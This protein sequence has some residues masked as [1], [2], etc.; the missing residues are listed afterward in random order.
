[1]TVPTEQKEAAALLQRLSG[2]APIE[3]P[4]SAVFV[5]RLT[6][7]KLK[8]AVRM[9]FADFTAA[10]DRQRFVQREL[11][12]NK[13]LAPAVYRDFAAIVRTRHDTLAIT[14]EPDGREVLD[15]VLRMAPVPADWF[16]DRPAALAQLT[17]PRLDALADLIAAYHAGLSPVEDWD[18]AA[19]LLAVVEENA[20]SAREAGLPEPAVSVWHQAAHAALEARRPWF[21]ARARAGLVRRAHGDLHLGN[22]LLWHGTPMPFDAL[23][24][25]EAMATIDLGYDL[26]FLLMDLDLKLGREASNRVLNRY[27]ARTLDFGLVAGLPLFLSL[28][29]MVR[30]HVRR[31]GDHP[32]S[33]D[34]LDAALRYLTP[35]SRPAPVVAIGGLPGTGKSTL[36][37][38]LAAT[39]GP[40]PG[41]VVLRSDEIRKRQHGVAPEQRLPPEAY[42]EAANRQVMDAV[43]AGLRGIAP[44]GHAAIAD[45]TFLDP[46][47]RAAAEQAARDAGVPFVGLWLHARLS[48]LE[49]RIAARRHDASDADVEVLHRAAE[50]DAGPINWTRLDATDADRALRAAERA[51]RKVCG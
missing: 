35:P 20:V 29:A 46:A 41:A 11:E 37:R 31:R 16:C 34:Y 44:A 14:P 12:L 47:H 25:D 5:G 21:T 15:W 51:I 7:W 2:G 42:S 27:L 19:R 50:A 38:S 49:S 4:I 28:R 8:K 40:A 18:G 43:F 6:A 13:P 26:A 24:F 48:V 17:P 23:E 39:L 3:T 32:D 9:P 1:M 30:A 33:G 36:A 22:I 10:E 45:A